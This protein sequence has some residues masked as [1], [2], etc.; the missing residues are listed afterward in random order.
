M[1]E[2][3]YT[4]SFALMVYGNNAKDRATT[5]VSLIGACLIKEI[6]YL[7]SGGS[8]STPTKTAPAGAVLN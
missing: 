7:L 1:V 4:Q 5:S 8:S 3:T 2:E 6:N